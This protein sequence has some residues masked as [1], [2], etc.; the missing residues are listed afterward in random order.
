MRHGIAGEADLA[1]VELDVA[2]LGDFPRRGQSFCVVFEERAQLVAGLQAV[3][4]VG[5][6]VRSGFVE[7]HAVADGDQRVVHSTPLAHVVVDLVG[8][9][10]VCAAAA[11][12][13]RAALED[14]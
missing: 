10:D 5:E 6:E 1:E 2:L 7:R 14:P 4:G 12:H 9:D 3:L 11:R 8:G 13:R